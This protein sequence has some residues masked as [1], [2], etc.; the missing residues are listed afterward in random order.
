[1]LLLFLYFNKLNITFTSRCLTGTQKFINALNKQKQGLIIIRDNKNIT[2]YNATLLN[3]PIHFNKIWQEYY[4]TLQPYR[5]QADET[6]AKFFLKFKDSS[7][8]CMV[9][10]IG[11]GKTVQAE[12]ELKKKYPHCL[13]LAADPDSYINADLVE[14]KLNGIFVKRGVVAEDSYTANIGANLYGKNAGEILFNK[15]F[16]EPPIGFFDF[17]VYYN[18]KKVID[19]LILDIEGSEFAIFALLAEQYDQLPVI[20]C[21]INVEFHHD[22]RLADSFLRHR[23]LRNFN[24]FIRHG[25]FALMKI[26]MHEGLHRMFFVNYIDKICIEKFLC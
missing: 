23:F 15:H 19:L 9:V 7:S 1:I 21:Q 20:I 17:F 12:L 25:I 3:I 22:Q 24:S 6:D 4:N 18:G 2:N 13:F 5:L 8:D 26:E 14:N 10:T 16:E 11:V